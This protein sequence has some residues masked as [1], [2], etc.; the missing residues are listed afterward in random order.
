MAVYA[1]LFDGTRLEFP[2]GTDPSVIAAT[3]KRVTQSMSSGAMAPP[4]EPVGSA[5]KPE[6]I[7]FVERNIGAAKRGIEQLS[8]TFGGLGLAGT[9][10]TGTEAETAA[11]MQQIKREQ[12]VPQETPGY[13]AA[14]IERIYKKEGLLSAAGSVPSYIT[15]QILQSA[16]SM[17][18]PLAA[19]AAA[20]AVSAPLGPAAPVVGALVGIGTYGVQQFGNFLTRQA[21]EKKDAKELDLLK[22]AGTAA[23]TAPLG[24]FADRFTAGIGGLGTK[25]AGEEILKELS[26]R[27]V[28]AKV[29]KRAAV[30]ASVG[31]IA[32]APLEVLE[33]AAERYQ[34]GLELTGDDAANEYKEAFF[35]AAAAGAGIGG[36][37]R[38][39]QAYQT[40]VRPGTTDTLKGPSEDEQRARFAFLNTI[41]SGTKDQITTD[42]NG[43]QVKIPGQ[44]GRYF[45]P[46]EQAE[47]DQLKQKFGPTTS[48]PPRTAPP[49][50]SQDTQAMIDEIS[51]LPPAAPP[52]VPPS[53]ITPPSDTTPPAAPIGNEIWE[54]IQN[55]DRSS[56][57]SIAQMT[58]IANV[59][60]YS[61][62]SMSRSYST[63]A[64]IVAGADIDPLRLGRKDPVV[65]EDGKKVPI[66]FGVVEAGDVI[67]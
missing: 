6:D 47:Y 26:A 33:Q 22:A 9:A 50:S 44:L 42:E 61:R 25:K 4:Q 20:T 19:G 18:G 34:A 45:T 10:L 11:K 56:P 12:A 66:Q 5:R 8:D 46:K 21:I 49:S 15:E 64:P 54:S 27:Q 65:G 39:I 59:P 29:G 57:A 51:G 52:I 24:Y 14:D 30:G 31:I 55:R 62:L 38:A 1:E 63:G 36:T 3:A 13:T 35:G 40:P 67:A 28:A 41:S 23:A 48:A 37:S 17:A 60:D 58:N 53:D 43:N 16:P 2:D 7:G 32:E